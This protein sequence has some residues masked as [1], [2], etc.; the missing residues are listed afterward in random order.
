MNA[1]AE[2][3]D[4][5]AKYCIKNNLHYMVT[6]SSGGLDS[7]VTLGIAEKACLFAESEQ[8]KLNSVALLMPCQSNSKDKI[9]GRK[10]AEQFNAEIIE[11]RLDS[12]FDFAMANTVQETNESVLRIVERTGGDLAKEKWE[13][14]LRFTQGNIKARLRMMLGTYHV[15]RMLKGIVLS[16]DNLS[17]YMMGFWT[18][19]GD[20]GDFGVIQNILKGIELYDIAEY[21]CVPG[22]II[23]AK[24]GDGLNIA[25]C[26]ED[27][28][29]CE[30]AGVDK[31][32]ITLIKSGF[33]ING[34][35]T[36]LENLPEVPGIDKT[37]V[38]NVAKR[39]LIG[40]YKRTGEITVSREQ[41]GLPHLREVNP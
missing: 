39:C 27:Q 4:A 12:V 14:S 23:K 32:M 29:G 41:L 6:G 10:V 9:L 16:T 18:L 37:T 20:I 35:I 31:I 2:G 5:L 1:V 19:H 26:A 13:E 33:D 7:A 25:G 34:N 11:I 40:A 28:I 8:F 36:Q 17:E 30:Y 24:P 22:E 15:A 21:L 3:A 38:Y